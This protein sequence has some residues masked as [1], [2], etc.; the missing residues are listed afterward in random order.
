MNRTIIITAVGSFSAPAAVKS[1]REAGYR[2]VGTDI[3]PQ[4]VIAESMSV[5]RFVRMPRADAGEAYLA[6]METLIAEEDAQAVIP[7]TDVEVDALNHVRER[8]LPA[9]LWLSPE[10]TL[11]QARD[12]EQSRLAAERAFR[13]DPELSE[14][15]LTIPTIRF[16][17]WLSSR[18]GGSGAEGLPMVL[19]PRDGRSSEGLYRVRTADE[20]RTA[21]RE[22][23][24]WGGEDRYLVQPLIEGNVV[25]VDTVRS[26]DGGC[27]AVPREELRRT[28][29][30]AGLAVRVFRDPLVEK[31]ACAVAKE[32]GIL[33]CVNFE[34][35]AAEDGTYRFLECN[36]RFS[37]G[38]AFSVTAGEDVIRRHIA[39]FAEHASVTG[40]HAR[41]CSIA[42]KY[43]EVVTEKC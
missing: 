41:P 11:V 36:P 4:E 29:N 38:I 37:G 22:I 31:A 33:G 35:I 43:V 7:L 39:V 14:R 15:F 5:D 40:N 19:K 12:K 25:T 8:L 20:L 42:R 6:A 1:C 21:V 16:S 30:G 3:N 32:L 18:Y 26:A 24:L 10:N 28:H 2:V 9:E 23:S 17:S 34:L 27:I 13:R